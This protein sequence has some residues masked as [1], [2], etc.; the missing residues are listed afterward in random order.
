MRAILGSDEEFDIQAFED[1]GCEERPAGARYALDA[2]PYLFF[3]ESQSGVFAR[4]WGTRGPEDVDYPPDPE[5]WPAYCV[6]VSG[7]PI[8]ALVAVSVAIEL[9]RVLGSSVRDSETRFTGQ[10][11]VSSGALLEQIRLKKSEFASPEDRIVC[12]VGQLNVPGDTFSARQ[13][14]YRALSRVFSVPGF[15]WVGEA[16]FAGRS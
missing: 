6:D 2:R 11:H 15:L 7:N 8:G 14:R 10:L 13:R 5:Q 3:K 4:V 12:F 16:E 1:D 9:A